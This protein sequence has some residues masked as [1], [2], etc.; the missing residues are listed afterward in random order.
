MSRK[1][2][3]LVGFATAAI[4]FGSLFA[5][6]GSEHF[7]GGRPMCNPHHHCLMDEYHYKHCCGIKTEKSVDNVAT[8]AVK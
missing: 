1:S 3:F 4:T 7:N 8:D 5:S 6:M 2:R